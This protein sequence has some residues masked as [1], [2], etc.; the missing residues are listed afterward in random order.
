M[1]ETNFHARE[2]PQSGWKAEG[3]E[4]KRKKKKVKTMASLASVSHYEWGTKAFW[5]AGGIE[6]KANS[7]QLLM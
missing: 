1:G 5:V 4:Q 2:I 7:V 3:V 6:N